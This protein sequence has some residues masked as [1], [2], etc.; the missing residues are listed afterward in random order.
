MKCSSQHLS[1]LYSRPHNI[2]YECNEKM[3]CHIKGICAKCDI[4][5][6][7][8]TDMVGVGSCGSNYNSFDLIINLNYPENNV[9]HHHIRMIGNVIHIGI[10]DHKDDSLYM[11]SLIDNLLPNIINKYGE[12]IKI[13]FHCF[14]GYSRSIILA[15]AYIALRYKLSY[16]DA[17]NMIKS[18]RRYICPLENWIK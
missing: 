14:S 17:Y 1:K 9:S 16:E 6:H 2:C 4:P 12:N 7:M 5:M 10:N 11:K 18:K 13:L 8:I 15:T 3:V